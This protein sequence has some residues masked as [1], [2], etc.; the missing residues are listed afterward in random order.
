MA[1][2]ETKLEATIFEKLA[3]PFPPS[4]V[5]WLPKTVDRTGRRALGLSYID[6]RSVMARL[7]EVVGPENWQDGLRY[8]GN[9]TFCDLSIRINGEWVIKSDTS[10][11]SAFEAEKGGASGAFKRAAVKWGIGRYLYD[12]DEVW[13]DCDAYQIKG[14]GRNGKD[15]WVFKDWTAKGMD[16]L[17]RALTAAPGPRSTG[18]PFAVERTLELMEEAES[19]SEL[20][21]IYEENYDQIPLPYRK[22]FLEAKDRRRKQLQDEERKTDDERDEQGN[23]DRQSRRRPRDQEPEQRRERGEPADRDDRDVEGSE[24]GSARED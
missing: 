4:C 5:E 20:R 16:D 24:G 18:K 22:E 14:G 2:A 10:G 1:K 7:D 9:R 6:A 15:K 3:A 8:E 13:A 21:R 23:A 11:D 17:L 19:L 12:V